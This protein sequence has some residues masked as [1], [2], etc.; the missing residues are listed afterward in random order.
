VSISTLAGYR[1]LER[2]RLR[3]VIFDL[4]ETLLD[5]G[6]ASPGFFEDQ[7]EQDFRPVYSYLAHAGF[8]LPAWGLFLE[9]MLAPYLAQ[10]QV[11]RH[12]FESIHIGD[13]MQRA[14]SAMGIALS[15]PALEACVR[16]TFQYSVDHAVLYPDVIPLLAVLQAQ[17]LATGLVSNT[18]WPSWCQ[19]ESLERLNVRDLLF[20]RIY[21]ADVPYAKPHP[22][23]FQHALGLLSVRPEE[24]VFVGDRLDLDIRGPHS[25]GMKAI[26]FRVPYRSES[27]PE[28]IPDDAVDSLADLPAALAR[29]YSDLS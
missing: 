6:G 16:L 5:P 27:S 12:T 2:R 7:A 24:A 10:R 20:P 23:I 18:I 3:A 19:D 26:L 22:S 15:A 14:L 17:G 25:A 4:G 9:Q 21:S 11:S 28:V 8:H 13:M 1:P 29:L